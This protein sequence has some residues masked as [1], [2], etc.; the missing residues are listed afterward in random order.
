MDYGMS[1]KSV[2]IEEV[3]EGVA[4]VRDSYG[5]RMR[6]STGVRRTG[7]EVPKADEEWVIDRHL[8]GWT[9]VARLTGEEPPEVSGNLTDGT[10]LANLLLALEARGIIRIGDLSG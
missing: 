10:A 7:Y 8:G 3:T 5:V 9:F 6:V 1:H 2:L 4:M